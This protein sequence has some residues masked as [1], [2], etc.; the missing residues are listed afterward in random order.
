MGAGGG[1]GGCRL[2]SILAW[3]KNHKKVTFGE[4]SEWWQ[5]WQIPRALEVELR[6]L[7]TIYRA[8]RSH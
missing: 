1:R 6:I 4:F 7:D 8:I 2:A 5:Q 3:F